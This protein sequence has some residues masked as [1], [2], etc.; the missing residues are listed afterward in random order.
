M[1]RTVKTLAVAAGLTA[2][3][4]LGAL[5]GPAPK[6][7][8][9]VPKAATPGAKRPAIPAAKTPTTPTAKKPG[10]AATPVAHKAKAKAHIAKAKHPKK[11]HKIVK[12]VKKTK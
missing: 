10:K 4:T 1:L 2:V 3:T 8:A 9:P 12:S 11:V 5:A 7:G 6:P